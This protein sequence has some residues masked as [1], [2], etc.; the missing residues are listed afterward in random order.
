MKY[1]AHYESTPEFTLIV[2]TKSPTETVKDLKL[3]FVIEYNKKFGEQNQL[4]SN[5]IDLNDT[6][7]RKQA[8]TTLITKVVKNLEDVFV[9]KNSNTP[10][11]DVFTPAVVVPEVVTPAPTVTTTT[12]SKSTTSKPTSSTPKPKVSSECD[13]KSKVIVEALLQQALILYDKQS[14]K[15]ALPL[16]ENVLSLYPQE[17]TTLYKLADIYYQAKKYE[18]SQKYIEL[19]LKYHAKDKDYTLYLL[20]AKICLAV[21][22]Y[23]D[24]ITHLKSACDAAGSKHKEYL[25]LRAMLGRALYDS[26][27]Q[28]NQQQGCDI[29]NTIVHTD[30]SVLEG[31]MGFA[32]VLIDRQQLG[33]ALTVLMQLLSRLANSADRSP[34]ADFTKDA[35]ADIVKKKGTEFLLS[36]LKDT[37]NS[38]PVYAFMS[39]VVKEYGAVEAAV[40]L[41]RLAYNADPSNA[42]YALNLV[43]NLEVCNKYPEAVVVIY[44]YLTANKP[45]GLSNYKLTNGNILTI[46][47]K[48]KHIDYLNKPEN[49]ASWKLP[50]PEGGPVQ[51]DKKILVVDD[52]DHPKADKPYT[53]FDLDLISLWCTIAKIFYVVGLL[54][55]LPLLITALEPLRKDRNLHM[56]T[57]RNEHAYFCCVSQL[58][59]HKQLPI[60]SAPPIYIAGDSHALTTSWSSITINGQ[61]R[62]FHPLLTTGLKMWHLRP[63]SKFFPKNNFYNV[64]TTAPKGSEI[65][66]QF[67]EID[68]REGIVVS[69][70]KCRY[71]T[72]EEGMGITID[73]YIKALKELVS[74]YNYKIYIH[75]VVPVLNETRVL[76][77]TFNKIFK[78][79]IE[80]TKELKWLD[81]FDQLLDSTVIHHFCVSISSLTDYT[82][83]DL[84]IKTEKKY[85]NMLE[86][87]N[88]SGD[89][90]LINSYENNDGGGSYPDESYGLIVEE[91][92]KA[93]E[94]KSDADQDNTIYIDTP[95]PGGENDEASLEKPAITPLPWRKLMGPFVLL[96]CEAIGNTSLFSYI[97][98]MIIH[99]GV[100]ADEDKV[101]YYAGFVAS[102]FSFAQFVSSF[103][104]GKMSD[105]YG[106]KPILVIGSVGSIISVLAV[107]LSPNLPLL[108]V[109]RTINGILNGNIGVIKTYIGEVTDKTNQV[110]AFGWIGLTWGFGSIVGPIVGGIL[111]QPA[112]NIPFIFKNNYF[113]GHLFP[114]FL[115]NLVI[116]ILTAIGLGFT[117]MTMNETLKTFKSTRNDIE[118]SNVEVGAEEKEEEEPMELESKKEPIGVD[119]DIDSPILSGESTPP[120]SNIDYE[121]DSDEHGNTENN[122]I[123]K[124]ESLLK[125]ATDA[126]K[127]NN[128]DL[129][130]TSLSGILEQSATL[131]ASGGIPKSSFKGKRRRALHEVDLLAKELTNMVNKYTP[132]I[133][134]DKL[135][136][137]ATMLYAAVGFVYTMYDE[138]FPIW[139]LAPIKHG[140]LS[141]T[142]KDIGICGAIGGVSVIL[143]QVFVVK[144]I[145]QKIGIIRTFKM[146][147]YASVGTFLLFPTL[148]YMAPEPEKS[149]KTHLVIFWIVLSIFTFI[150]SFCGQLVFTPVMTLVNNSANSARK[151]QANG[152]G[153][154]LVAF[155]RTIGP[156]LASVVVAWSVSSGHPFPI[157]HWFVFIIM[158]L[159]ML[160]P[161]IYTNFLP[162][163]LNAPIEED[164]NEEN[165]LMMH[166]E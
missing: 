161:A 11:P 154:S 52:D 68:C 39:S 71:N 58:M 79:K 115:P 85:P 119:I 89:A 153:Q 166:M 107:G 145:S 25:T 34:V 32:H 1:Y 131:Q 123:Q 17:K 105:K 18:L 121:S 66:F 163:S 27:N 76:V 10:I 139:S 146:G 101:G 43:H 92:E 49:Y 19:A 128:Q 106:R 7:G 4:T 2:Q 74:K 165:S 133:F 159:M 24:A 136:L 82:I 42:N 108:I 102:S 80:A 50:V 15:S 53:K 5:C 132:S 67:G 16:F 164:G 116:G 111:S 57:A 30:E 117:Y 122:D 73:I 157:N 56:T 81:F 51:V 104:W 29:L 46:L 91:K 120:T 13:P 47:G 126:M 130:M 147:C 114:F 158:S 156:T 23:E 151:G 94:L 12:S 96:V 148:N 95:T 44:Q 20:G 100:T 72:I 90:I 118:M 125:D 65:V 78:Q 64:T 110:E 162:T 75:P 137:S 144:P 149:S 150:R 97:G 54:E 3:Q 21:K 98:F 35:I 87:E 9:V 155:C 93:Q 6:K 45:R 143:M 84:C 86:G 69:V 38:A 142:S 14:Y 61:P 37:V 129:E 63:A 36:Q 28:H 77:K 141:F 70:E 33:D 40:D 41:M 22:E 88:N 83:K 152:L 127:K 26:G 103:F 31:L 134:K 8:D 59:V 62:L 140:G 55:P 124:K 138:S 160:A 48:Q 113:F 135:I 112:Q 109:A 60:I 99:M